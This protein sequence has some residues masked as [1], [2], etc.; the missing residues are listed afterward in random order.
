V[1]DV[2]D[3]HWSGFMIRPVSIPDKAQELICAAGTALERGIVNLSIKIRDYI[4]K[5]KQDN[6]PNPR[7]LEVE[8]QPQPVN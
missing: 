8:P 3:K 7:N 2:I 6:A 1:H 4:E 5:R